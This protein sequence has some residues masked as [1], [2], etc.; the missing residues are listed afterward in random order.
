MSIECEGAEE[1]ADLIDVVRIVG[2]HKDVDI[3]G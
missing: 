2:G 3:D 1:A